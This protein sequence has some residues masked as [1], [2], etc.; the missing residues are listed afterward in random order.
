MKRVAIYGASDDLVEIESDIGNDELDCYEEKVTVRFFSGEGPCFEVD[1][2]HGHGGWTTSF[3]F[4]EEWPEGGNFPF[5]IG[6][7]V[8][9]TGYSWKTVISSDSG[10]S[11][12]TVINGKTVL[13]STD[14]QL[15]GCDG[16]ECAQ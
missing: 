11:I 14:V 8:S 7:E 13:Y 3:R 15:I 2:E 10:F 1:L 4:S 16:E 12:D 6:V 9:P 5:S